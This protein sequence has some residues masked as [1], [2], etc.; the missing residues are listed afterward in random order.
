MGPIELKSLP[1]GPPLSPKNRTRNIKLARSHMKK[2]DTE[3]FTMRGL[4]TT[5]TD[6]RSDNYDKAE[7]N[8]NYTF[9]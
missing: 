9:D 2:R 5:K 4:N 8:L 1:D 7:W 6:I 3:T